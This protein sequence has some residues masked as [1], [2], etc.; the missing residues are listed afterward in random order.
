MKFKKFQLTED[1]DKLEKIVND[2]FENC[3]V[4]DKK[5]PTFGNLFVAIGL[6]S[7]EAFYNNMARNDR[8]GEILT[9]AYLKLESIHEARLFDR[10]CTGSIFWL[11]S[12][13]KN[14]FDVF[15]EQKSIDSEDS[16]GFNGS[17]TI[18]VVSKQK[19]N[20]VNISDDGDDDFSNESTTT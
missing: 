2:F 7:F 17:L 16:K 12:L 13:R 10:Y 6:K 8:V 14:G 4:K 5:P 3:D 18:E 20:N 15:S 1:I 9:Y 11:K 19:E